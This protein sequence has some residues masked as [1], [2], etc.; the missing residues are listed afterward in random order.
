MPPNFAAQINSVL[1]YSFLHNLRSH[2]IS[3]AIRIF[4]NINFL[5]RLDHEFV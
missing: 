4:H 3:F 5:T 1:K 2:D